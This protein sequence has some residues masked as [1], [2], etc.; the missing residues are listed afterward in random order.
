MTRGLSFALIFLSTILGYAQTQSCALALNRAEDLYEQGKLLEIE[1]ARFTDCLNNGGF[2]EGE[3][4]RAR[5]LLIKMA[6]FTDN[7]PRAEQE[8]VEL[9]Q[10]DPVHELEQEDPTEMTVLLNKFRTW[11]IYRIEGYGGANM[12]LTGVAQEYTTFDKP[13]KVYANDLGFQVGVRV[14]KHLRYL[15][16]G[17]EVGGGFEFRSSSYTVTQEPIVGNI[18]QDPYFSTLIKNRQATLRVPLFARYN[19]NYSVNGRFIPYVFAGGSLDYLISAKYAD[20]S[21]SGGITASF[22]NNNFSDLKAFDQVNN[23]N[24]SIVGGLGAKF[25]AGKGNFL[26]GEVRYDK[27]LMLY[28]VPEERY[29][30]PQ[31][32]SDLAYVEDDVFLNYVTVNIGYVRSIFKPVKLR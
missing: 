14:T 28:N 9:L 8:L 3:Q 24:M 31:L 25:N 20:A 23:L 18:D 10:I 7:E 2:S 11:P 12:A 19:F 27:S 21:R 30:N 13:E 1:T 6:I 4:V 16:T 32:V 22:S 17:L 26:F 15:L 5:K 29:S